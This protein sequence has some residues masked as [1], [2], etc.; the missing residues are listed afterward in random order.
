MFVVGSGVDIPLIKPALEAATSLTL[1]VPEEPEMA[2]AQG[3]ALASANSPL[4]ASSTAAQAYALDTVGRPEYRVPYF[5]AD[6]NTGVD[7]VAYSAVPDEPENADLDENLSR[8]RPLLLAGSS[9]SVVVISAV[10]A[11]EIALAI[12]I[13]P[14]VALRPSPNENIIVPT[15]QAP[16]PTIAP[17][18]EVRPPTPVAEP[19]AI[20]PRVVAPAPAP[21]PR[22]GARGPAASGGS[23]GPAAGGGGSDGTGSGAGARAPGAPCAPG[24]GAATPSPTAGATGAAGARVVAHAGRTG[25]ARAVAGPGRRPR[26]LRWAARW[27]DLWPW[28]LW[29]WARLRRLRAQVVVISPILQSWS[30]TIGCCRGHMSRSVLTPQRVKSRNTGNSVRKEST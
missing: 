29:R 10:V 13:R 14:T 27:W 1:S 25:A 23:R 22:P 8:R 6:G 2:L 11:L 30:L 19:R 18:P 3:A 26:W 20:A 12:S 4:F 15:Q 21:A 7:N 24:A 17:K 9:L 28:A 16:A 5:S